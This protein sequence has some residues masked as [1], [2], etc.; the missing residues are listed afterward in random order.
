[1]L[2]VCIVQQNSLVAVQKDVN[3][4]VNNYRVEGQYLL[5]QYIDQ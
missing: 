4:Y 2:H 3:N 1:M 5:N